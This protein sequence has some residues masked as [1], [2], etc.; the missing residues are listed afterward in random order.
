MQQPRLVA[1]DVDGTL[2]A[3]L[4]PSER[5]IATVAKVLASGTPFVLV[6]GRPP[7]WIPPIANYLPGLGT[8]VCANGAVLYD[9][10]TDR[11]LCAETLQPAL[12]GELARTCSRLLPGAWL[13]VERVGRG[14]FDDI[15]GQFLCEVDVRLRQPEAY[16][17]VW[18]SSQH[19]AVPREQLLDA[20]AIKLLVKDPARSSDELS[21]ILTPAL[22]GAVDLTFASS[23]GLV[24]MAPAGVT[25]A[26]GLAAV[27]AA[28]GV[29]QADVIAFGDMPND[30]DMLRW[31]GHGV[32]MGNAHPDVLA[33]ADEVTARNTDD[34]VALVLERWF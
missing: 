18:S 1:S 34:G 17:S 13:A 3:T 15:E 8:A 22:G 10:P 24:E 31:A 16:K 33:V 11:V 6:T 27:A 2:L 4:Q 14:A 26:T 25:K 23:N 29:A 7:R 5:T 30:V 32:A 28:A 19:T 9:I 21:A 20:P 12:L